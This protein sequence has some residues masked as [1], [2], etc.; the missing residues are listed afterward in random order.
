MQTLHDKS[1]SI[2]EPFET[3]SDAFPPPLLSRLPTRLIELSY[4][5]LTRMGGYFLQP[6]LGRPEDVLR[7]AGVYRIWNPLLK[8]LQKKDTYSIISSDILIEQINC[9]YV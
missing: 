1:P 5:H 7:F 2:S 8:L 6:I 9:N 4:P 3:R